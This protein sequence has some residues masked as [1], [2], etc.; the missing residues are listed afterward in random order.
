MINRKIIG[1]LVSFNLFKKGKMME[2]KLPKGN[3]FLSLKRACY[4]QS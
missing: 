3:S 1:F 2:D 4:F